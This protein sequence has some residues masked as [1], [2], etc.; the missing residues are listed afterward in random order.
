V[1][2]AADVEVK[3]NSTDTDTVATGSWSESFVQRPRRACLLSHLAAGLMLLVMPSP[4][5]ALPDFWSIDRKRRDST[6]SW[7][8]GVIGR[9]VSLQEALRISR[10]IFERAQRERRELARLEAERI[11]RQESET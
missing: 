11:L 2:E 1:I 7:Q 4:A 9:P 3:G 10:C 8:L 5:T 6:I